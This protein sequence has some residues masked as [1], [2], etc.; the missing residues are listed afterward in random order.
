MSSFTKLI[1]S[2]YDRLN[3]GRIG[4]TN[5]IHT[6]PRSL[7]GN[8]DRKRAIFLRSKTEKN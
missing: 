4:D 3:L 6:E 2:E 1:D 8:L 7:T 5:Y